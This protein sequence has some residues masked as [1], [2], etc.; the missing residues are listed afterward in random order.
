MLQALLSF[1][2]VV[3]RQA[4]ETREREV[5]PS[6]TAVTDTRRA[7]GSHRFNSQQFQIEGLES[8]NHCL[9]SPRNTL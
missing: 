4:A 8:Q 9:F 6:A 3:P 2:E 5:Q 1:I 7:V